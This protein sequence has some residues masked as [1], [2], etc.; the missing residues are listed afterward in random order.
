MTL[1]SQSDYQLNIVKHMR[2]HQLPLSLYFKMSPKKT[3]NTPATETIKVLYFDT[4]AVENN[5][6]K[7][8]PTDEVSNIE[9]TVKPLAEPSSPAPSTATE[10]NKATLL[11]RKQRY[12]TSK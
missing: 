1:Y 5:V 7:P 6:C 8:E 2:K 9:N 12:E 11:T 4:K 10:K 3:P